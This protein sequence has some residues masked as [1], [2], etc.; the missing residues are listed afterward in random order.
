[1]GAGGFNSIEIS[2]TGGGAF[3]AFFGSSAGRD[4]TRGN[5]NAFFGASAGAGNIVGTNNTI[6]GNFA[7]V[8]SGDLYNA[9]AIGADARVDQSNSLVLGSVNVNVGI[10]T[11]APV[12][13]LQVVSTNDNNPSVISAWDSRHFVIGGTA[14]TGGIGMSYDQ[15]NGVGYV[16]ALSPNRY[17]RNLILQS[18][19]GNIGIGTSSPD[20]RLTVNGNADKPGGGSWAVFSDERLKTITG[21]FTTGLKAVMQLQP[22]RY[23]YKPDNALGINSSGEH[24]GFGARAVQ[25]I[26][27]EAV[28]RNDKGYLL[29]NN[30]PILWTMLNAIKEQQSEI[31]KLQAANAALKARLDRLEQQQNDPKLR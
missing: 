16:E 15:T 24:V 26:I 31:E 23:E 10:G 6:I 5:G 18:G 4:N 27:P 25:Q 14:S 28:T 19:G 30:D 20:M 21:R 1:K 8:G 2:S 22:L 3:N 12:G 17:W 9:T 29:I 13:R 7:I 11:A